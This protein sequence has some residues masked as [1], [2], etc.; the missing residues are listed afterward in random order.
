MLRSNVN[1]RAAANHIT[2]P[3]ANDKPARRP[4]GPRR[5]AEFGADGPDSGHIS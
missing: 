2:A 5:V 4:L 3:E 1:F